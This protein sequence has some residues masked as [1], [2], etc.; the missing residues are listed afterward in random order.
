VKIARRYPWEPDEAAW[1]ILTG[2]PPWH[3]PL[4][5]HASGPNS[6]NHGLITIEAAH[7]VPKEAVSSFYAEVKASR[8]PAPTPSARRLAVF[9]FVI[10]RASAIGA[11]PG[12]DRHPGELALPNWP[13]LTAAWNQ[14]HPPGNRWHYHD[15]RNFRRDFV[16]TKKA[17][18]EQG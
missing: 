9:R 10:E 2:S 1:L 5:A 8:A 11:N 4:T 6:E 7:W 17:L 16:E 3:S 12:E 13:T 15:F 18:Y 14:D